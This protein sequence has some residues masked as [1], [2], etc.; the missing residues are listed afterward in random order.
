MKSKIIRELQAPFL[1]FASPSSVLTN[2]SE[3]NGRWQT[4]LF[5]IRNRRITAQYSNKNASSD[6]QAISA[7]HCCECGDPI[8]ERNA[9]PFRVVG[10]VQVARRRSNLEQTMGTV[11]ASKQQISTSSNWV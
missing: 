9:W 6:H 3:I 2:N 10:L 11:M 1:L 5:S 4:S 8:D 7:T